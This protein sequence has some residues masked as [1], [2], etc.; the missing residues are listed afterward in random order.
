M[1]YVAMQRVLLYNTQQ[2]CNGNGEFFRLRGP[3]DHP[4]F[5]PNPQVAGTPPLYIVGET[6][7]LWRRCII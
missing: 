1:A 2:R 3:V 7:S 5:G 4:W 6:I